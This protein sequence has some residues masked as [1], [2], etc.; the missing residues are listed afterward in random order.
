MDPLLGLEVYNSTP[1][2]WAEEAVRDGN[3]QL[4][5]FEFAP[6]LMLNDVL[7]SVTEPRGII[8]HVFVLVEFSSV[9][10]WVDNDHAHVALIERIIILALFGEADV[11]VPILLFGELSHDYLR[12]FESESPHFGRQVRVK[13]LSRGFFTEWL[14]LFFA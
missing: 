2:V 11:A 8:W 1:E 13:L 5:L 12:I 3:S 4:I 6:P 7:A 9:A 10:N 14:L